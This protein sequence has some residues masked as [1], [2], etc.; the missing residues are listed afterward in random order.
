MAVGSDIED[1]TSRETLLE[2]SLFQVVT[3]QGGGEHLMVVKTLGYCDMCYQL[4]PDIAAMLIGSLIKVLQKQEGSA[5][6]TQ[7]TI[8]IN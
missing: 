7:Q 8:A 2:I 5:T 1:K 4:T 3:E 6:A